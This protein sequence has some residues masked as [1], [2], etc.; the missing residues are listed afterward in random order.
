MGIKQPQVLV[1]VTR[2]RFSEL[3]GIELNIVESLVKNRSVPVIKIGKHVL[4]NVPA[5]NRA[6]I[7][8]QIRI[9]VVGES[10]LKVGG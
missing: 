1:P 7:D 10:T 3:T 8:A 4:V 9:E 6:C 2:E 5:L